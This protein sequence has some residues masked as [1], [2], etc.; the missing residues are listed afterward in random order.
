MKTTLELPDELLRKAKAVAAERRTTLRAL[1]EHALHR[2]IG[3]AGT[4][5]LSRIYRVDEDG[6]PYLPSRGA[7]VTSEDV[8]RLLEEE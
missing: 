1:V 8:Y 5:D 2:E 4:D 7:K 6:L 3:S